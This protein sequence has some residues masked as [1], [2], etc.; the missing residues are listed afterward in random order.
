MTAV[1]DD[2]PPEIS[3]RPVVAVEKITETVDAVVNSVMI[4]EAVVMTAV[5]ED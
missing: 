1:T 4:F 2:W 3:T 5:T